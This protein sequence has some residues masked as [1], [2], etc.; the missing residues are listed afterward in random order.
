MTT[1]DVLGTAYTINETDE[2]TE[3]R[4]CDCDGFCDKTTK[5]ICITTPSKDC[6]L[7]DWKWYRNKILRHEIIHAFLFESGLQENFKQDPYGVSETLVDWF[8]IQFPKIQK[9]F[10]ELKI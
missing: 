7:G 4:L 8:A 5:E 10:D 2:Q 3:K 1:I 6:N 9:V